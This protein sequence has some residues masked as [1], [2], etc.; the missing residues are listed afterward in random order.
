MSAERKPQFSPEYHESSSFE[1]Q[2]T[3]RN[4]SMKDRILEVIRLGLTVLSLILGIIIVGTSGD[5]LAVYSRT[6]L[7]DEY[8]LPLWPYDFNLGPIIALV[9]CG[10]IMVLTSA[11]SLLVTKVPAVSPSKM[12]DM[13]NANVFQLRYRP[14]INKL[15]SLS[16][17]AV[18]AIAAIVA[19]SFFYGINSSDT[20][21]TVQSWSCF[22]SDIDTDAEPHWGKIC[23]QSQAALY[24]DVVMIPLQ[25]IIGA[26]AIMS[27]IKDK[28]RTLTERKGSP[29]LS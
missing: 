18:G 13:I 4:G 24:L 22:W 12:S 9:A 8:Q 10:S 17:P 1:D 7:G 15:M 11:I 29:A 25:I 19:T 16:A 6:H 26:L 14:T 23:K 21:A 3:Q 27:A 5:N 28:R 2:P 20:V